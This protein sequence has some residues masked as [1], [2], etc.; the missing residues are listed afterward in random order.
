MARCSTTQN[1]IAWHSMALRNIALHEIALIKALSKCDSTYHIT[2]QCSAAHD[3]IAQDRTE[4]CLV[5]QTGCP[6]YFDSIRF[7]SIEFS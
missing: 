2:L 5:R 6:F 3:S 4:H 7:D 1:I